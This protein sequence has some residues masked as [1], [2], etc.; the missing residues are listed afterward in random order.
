KGLGLAAFTGIRSG[1]NWDAGAE[2]EITPLRFSSFGWKDWVEASLLL[3]G[4]R[5]QPGELPAWTFAHAGAR[6]DLH[7]GERF[8]WNFALR[9]NLTDRKALSYRQWE[10]GLHVRF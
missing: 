10:G 9:T 7:M 2:L 3:G 6:L 5:W 1:K 4:T 8:G